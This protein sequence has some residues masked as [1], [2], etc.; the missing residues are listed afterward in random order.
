MFFIGDKKE[1]NIERVYFSREFINI[2]P[3]TDI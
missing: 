1:K 3:I 2:F